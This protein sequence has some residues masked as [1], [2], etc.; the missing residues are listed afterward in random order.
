MNCL[1]RSRG[2]P[3]AF[4]SIRWGNQGLGALHPQVSAWTG[5]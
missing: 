5:I 3:W 4:S 1:E 2:S